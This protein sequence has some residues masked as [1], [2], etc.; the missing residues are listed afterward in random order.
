[1]RLVPR[2]DQLPPSVAARLGRLHGRY[3]QAQAAQD[4]WH[5]AFC[6]ELAAI[7]ADEDLSVREIAAVLEVSPS[8]VQ[9]WIGQARRLDAKA[10]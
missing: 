2:R 7:R 9:H 6:L 4:S 3:L 8:A 1:V 5:D 10:G